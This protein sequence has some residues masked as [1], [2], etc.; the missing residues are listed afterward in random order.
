MAQYEESQIEFGL[1]SVVRDPLTD[2]QAQLQDNEQALREVEAQI[3]ESG[4]SVDSPTGIIPIAIETESRVL[5]PEDINQQQPEPESSHEDSEGPRGAIGSHQISPAVGKTDPTMQA[6]ILNRRQELLESRDQL[7]RLVDNEEAAVN[8]DQQRASER[9]HDYG[10][11]IY[12][13]LRMLAE[14]EG[15]IKELIEQSR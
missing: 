1:L 8:D 12:M 5:P 2:H 6:T 4:A 10:P 14:K 13:W 15:L 7:Q 9:R 11:L 3:S